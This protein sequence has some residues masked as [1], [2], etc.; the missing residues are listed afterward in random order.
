MNF[1]QML[2]GLYHDQ[3]RNTDQ[4]AK[5]VK[6]TK[7]R[8]HYNI[9]MQTLLEAHHKATPYLCTVYLT[10]FDN[11]L[12]GFYNPITE[13]QIPP[14]AARDAISKLDRIKGRLMDRNI[15]TETLPTV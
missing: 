5:A 10:L 1:G 3:I 13:N 7:V 15:A 6:F 2:A 8:R 14:K 4:K 9:E 11:P 12:V